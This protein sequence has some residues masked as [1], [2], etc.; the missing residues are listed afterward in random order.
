MKKN[1]TI[2]KTDYSEVPIEES[3]E[4][5]KEQ[6]IVLVKEEEEEDSITIKKDIKDDFRYA[7]QN[8]KTIIETGMIAADNLAVI[9]SQSEA[10]R[11]FECLSQLLQ[12]NTVNNKMLLD[13]DSQ[14]RNLLEGKDDGNGPKKVI[15][16]NTLFVGTTTDIQRMIEEKIK[17]GR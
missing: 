16:H 17:S 11:V 3:L 14:M 15:N 12:I 10:P 8:I 13:L 9:A 1:K 5:L 6:G 2:T 4:V 7:R